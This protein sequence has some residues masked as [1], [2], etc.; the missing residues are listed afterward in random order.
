MR[1]AATLVERISNFAA[2]V[3]L[4]IGAIVFV[5]W[6]ADIDAMRR[7]FVSE[8]HM[9][10]N[11][12]VCFMLCGIAL[13]LLLN[14][15]EQRFARRIAEL[16]AL[17]VAAVGLVTMAEHATG[18]ESG[19]DLLLFPELVRTHRYLPPGRMAANS[20][21][22]MTLAAVGILIL[23]WR[24]SGTLRPSAWLSI[25]GLVISAVAMVG[26]LYN[27][28]MLYLGDLTAGMALATAIAFFVLH[29][30]IFFARPDV[31]TLMLVARGTSGM[32]A[33][34]LLVAIVLVPL[35]LGKFILIAREEQLVSR[36]VGMAIFVVAVIAII[37]V[38]AMR[39]AVSMDAGERAREA[40]LE[41][42]AA[43]RREAE[44][45]IDAKNDFL[46]VMSHELRTPLHAIIGYSSLLHEGIPD[47]PSD[48]QRRQLDRIT[49]SARH[50][51]ALIDEVLALSRLELG[52]D[53]F[54]LRETLVSQ[55]VR[56]AAAMVETQAAE[57]GLQFVLDIQDESIVIQTDAKKLRQALINLLG[58][59]V[60]FTEEGTIRLHVHD[61][62]DENFVN[63]DVVDTG[64]GI[65]PEHLERVFDSFWQAD[66]APSRRA[67]GVGLGL[68]VTRQLVRL[69]GGEVSVRSSIGQ[70]STFSV[71]LPK[72][73]WGATTA[74]FPRASPTH[75]EAIRRH[76]RVIPSS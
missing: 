74:E 61:D 5:G 37:L 16:L 45:A 73:W 23:D 18:W 11:T 64:R 28:Q 12:S 3:T 40:L 14:A 50:L 22:A 57:K 20:A 34:R 33:R 65:A 7:V 35:M 51:L 56:D 44:R 8:V 39:S 27:A 26:Y 6:A 36:E 46:A 38:I 54:Q 24:G 63:F 55:V 47:T 53:Q 58:N 2:L 60:K 66:Q 68:H 10:P 43:A 32:M 71:R 1:A 72:F 4:I 42:E 70:G 76:E 9:L 17:I 25:G 30:S 69:L 59:A 52:Q 67:G 13:L 29:A 41:R 31:G 19:I 75:A 48:G 15:P 62:A 21:T 49:S